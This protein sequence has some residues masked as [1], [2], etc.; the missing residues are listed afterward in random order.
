[1]MK[2]GDLV[3]WDGG[4]GG[5]ILS[6]IVLSSAAQPSSP[7]AQDSLEMV[8]YI[9]VLWQT[10]RKTKLP[11]NYVGLRILSENKSEKL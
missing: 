2:K 11:A 10:G 1:M 6:G 5:N 9:T 4:P 8:E 7:D 3:I